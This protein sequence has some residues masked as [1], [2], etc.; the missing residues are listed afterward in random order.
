M[1]YIKNPIVFW[2]KT[3]IGITNGEKQFLYYKWLNLFEPEVI[4]MVVKSTDLEGREETSRA[5]SEPTGLY[6]IWQKA[7]VEE[8]L[9]YVK[10]SSKTE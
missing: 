1:V 7:K 2:W 4:L 5:D 6:K 9:V 3:R 10:D 8:V